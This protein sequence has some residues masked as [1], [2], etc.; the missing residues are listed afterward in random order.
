MEEL[1][2]ELLDECR[3][4]TQQGKVATYIPELAKGN[5]NDLG[6]FGGFRLYGSGLHGGR[7]GFRQRSVFILNQ[8]QLGPD[9]AN[10]RTDEQQQEQKD[11]GNN[12]MFSEPFHR[13]SFFLG[14]LHYSAQR[15]IWQLF[16]TSCQKSGNRFYGINQ[17]FPRRDFFIRK[18]ELPFDT[19]KKNRGGILW[20]RSF[21]CT[22][23]SGI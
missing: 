13:N 19:M 15:L 4:Y 12:L 2:E 17:I 14:L 10:H 22:S 5:I 1:L 23:A 6:R 7:R 18:I 8:P 16:C 9:E 3:P 11:R 20:T 21:T